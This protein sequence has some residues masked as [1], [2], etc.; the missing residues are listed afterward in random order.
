[1]INKYIKIK[2]SESFLARLVH[3]SLAYIFIYGFYSFYP[4]ENR[5]TGLIIQIIAFLMFINAIVRFSINVLY[6]QKKI[7]LKLKNIIKYIASLTVLNAFGWSAMLSCILFAPTLDVHFA[8]LASLISFS[9]VANSVYILAAYPWI[10]FTFSFCSLAPLVI[11]TILYGHQNNEPKFYYFSFLFFVYISYVYRQTKRAN[12]EEIDRYTLE[13]EL[14][15]SIIIQNRSSKIIQEQNVINF[16]NSRLSSLGEMTSSIAHEINNPL[17]IVIGNIQSILRRNEDLKEEVKDNLTRTLIAAERITKIIKSMKLFSNK[18]DDQQLK[19]VSIRSILESSYNLYSERA[20]YLGIEIEINLNHDCEIKCNQVQISQ[21]LINL[22]NNAIDAVEFLENHE[23]K[24]IINI[25]QMNQ[26]LA[27]NVINLGPQ[28]KAEII[29]KI[30][31][32]FYTSKPIGKG[33][34]LGLSI[35]KKLAQ[36]NGGNLVLLPDTPNTTFQLTIPI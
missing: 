13:Y 12:K 35:S 31:L 28:I 30:F 16:H 17:T 22:I 1:M 36:S 20:K 21:I 4:G 14:R 7:K 19:Y 10:N 32:P 29:E 23:R 11:F 24:I 8:I 15:K 5:E 6:H 27:I 2:S 26:C 25:F 33:T 3:S 34:G 9:L 18:N